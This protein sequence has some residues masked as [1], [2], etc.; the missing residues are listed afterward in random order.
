[1]ASRPLPPLFFRTLPT[2]QTGPAE[3][4]PEGWRYEAPSWSSAGLGG[5]VFF[6]LVLLA[7]AAAV[8]LAIAGEVGALRA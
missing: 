1:M 8:T 3:G 7:Q 5:R 4:A 6:V 2:A